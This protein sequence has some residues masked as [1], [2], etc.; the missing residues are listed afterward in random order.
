MKLSLYRLLAVAI[1][2]DVVALVVAF[3]LRHAEHGAAGK[4]GAIGWFTLLADTLI[5]LAL[6]SAV[7]VRA[8]RGRQ[9]ARPAIR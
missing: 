5:V 6:T 3:A 2:V 8:L 7:F 4:I 1:A 9:A